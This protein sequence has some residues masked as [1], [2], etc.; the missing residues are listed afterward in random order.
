MSD[1]LKRL[2]KKY[3]NLIYGRFVK[4]INEYGIISDG[5]C[6]E[7]C[8]EGDC[9]SLL[10]AVLFDEIK[11]YGDI[12]FDYILTYTGKSSCY[13]KYQERIKKLG[14][15]SYSEKE[16]DRKYVSVDYANRDEV[17]RYILRNLICEGVI[18]TIRPKE[19]FC[20]RPLYYV[21]QKDIYN[22]GK[23][24]G[25][26]NDVIF[27]SPEDAEMSLVIERLRKINNQVGDSIISSTSNVNLQTVL[28]YTDNTGIHDFKEWYNDY[29]RR[30]G[31]DRDT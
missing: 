16:K 30:W 31:N 20:I 27:V 21:C 2:N 4:V 18:K 29:N 5:D 17:E 14:I 28:S 3:R 12:Q 10:V 11:K 1:L 9:V 8:T 7:L 23:Y 6:I 19:E 15:T 24:V 25:I 22:W 26:A 13:E